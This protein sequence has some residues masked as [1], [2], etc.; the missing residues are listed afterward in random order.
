MGSLSL[1]VRSA[2]RDMPVQ[3][4]RNEEGKRLVA[5]IDFPDSYL[6]SRTDQ[7]GSRVLSAHRSWRLGHLK[8]RVV[9]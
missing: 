7:E 4:T 8:V 9:E 2:A 3:S 6:S 5:Q 1:I